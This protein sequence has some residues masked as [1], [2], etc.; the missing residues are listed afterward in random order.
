MKT[1]K[2]YNPF[3]IAGYYSP[4][5]FCDR[6]TETEKITSALNNDRNVSLMSARR[7]GKTGLIHHVFHKLTESDSKVVCIY[8]DIYPT[9][10]LN[11]FVRIF[12]ENVLGKADANLEKAMNKFAAF[13][14]S[15]R[16]FQ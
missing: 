8:M 14:K 6:E 13:F 10:N 5:Y 16:H 3:L 1:N 4:D 2:P 7:Y 11:D 12:S 9:Q 15:F